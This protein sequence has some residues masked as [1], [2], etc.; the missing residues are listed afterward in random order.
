MDIY[1]I[2]LGLFFGSFLSVVSRRYPLGE[3][4]TK[5]R[6][7]CPKCKKK[8]NWYDNIPLVSYVL[9]WGKCRKCNKKISLRYPLIE[10]STALVFWMFY[11]F[12]TSGVCSTQLLC[13]WSRLFGGLSLLFVFFLAFIFILIFVVDLEHM[14]IPDKFV[15]FGL[16]VSFFLFLFSDKAFIFENL[17]SAGLFGSFF[18]LL[19]LLTSG[20]GMGLG[21]VKLSFLVGFLLGIKMSFYWMILSF[22][23]GAIVG[24]I[25]IAMGKAKFGRHIPFGPF[26]VF[27]FFLTLLFE[28]VIVALLP[29]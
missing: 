7:R 19:N 17:F 10:T 22:L 5:G 26:M 27:S 1:A 4:F 9:L 15:F 16:V 8:I 23:T 28:N 25:L 18:L 11:R 14:L 6:S 12:Y 3:G 21:D 24:I 13:E 2:F 29:I 20:K